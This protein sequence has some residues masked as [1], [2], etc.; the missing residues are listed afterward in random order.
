MYC[1][2]HVYARL[3][4][5]YADMYCTSHVCVWVRVLPVFWLWTLSST[6]AS[7]LLRRHRLWN[8]VLY[9]TPVYLGYCVIAVWEILEKY[10]EKKRVGDVHFFYTPL[11]LSFHLQCSSIFRVRRPVWL[12]R[13]AEGALHCVMSGV[14]MKRLHGYLWLM[15]R[16]CW[17]IREPTRY[18]RFMRWKRLTGWTRLRYYWSFGWVRLLRFSG[19]IA[20]LSRLTG[21]FGARMLFNSAGVSCKLLSSSS[22][23][24][25]LVMPC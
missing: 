16:W 8:Y 15:G 21:T 2:V 18:L 1:R 3:G 9:F 22:R 23:R 4:F 11:F 6:C 20:L 19:E 14:E 17:N 13:R 25:G 10:I 5:A 12:Y 24:W 7:W